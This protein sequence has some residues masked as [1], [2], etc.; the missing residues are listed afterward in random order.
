MTNTNENRP[1]AATGNRLK[2]TVAV[3]A[4]LAVAG[5]A[6][7]GLSPAGKSGGGAC[8]VPN[9]ELKQLARGEVAA[10]NIPSQPGSFPEL[11]FKA[12]DGTPVTLSSFR[13]KTVL[14]NLWATWCV[15]CRLEMP[16]LDKLQQEHGGDNF[17]VIA[18]NVDTS[19]PERPRKWLADNA[20]NNLGFYTDDS[21][22]VLKTLQK[23]GHAVGLPTTVL[24]NASGCEVGTLR[25]GAEWA[26]DDAV[27]L[28]RTVAEGTTGRE[29]P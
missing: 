13:G 20:I 15:P 2:I 5:A 11:T 27:K 12:A 7:L 24:V 6:Y 9:E 25:G 17:Q 21:G 29:T 22:T 16:A 26:S 4:I 19:G 8:P 3:A 23:S 1:G 10:F 14:V 28:I 18:I